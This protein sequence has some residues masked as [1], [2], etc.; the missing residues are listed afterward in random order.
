MKRLFI[1]LCVSLFSCYSLADGAFGT[2]KG[3]TKK[4]LE[5][6]GIILGNLDYEGYH[7]SD[8]APLK[9]DKFKLYK[10]KFKNNKLCSIIAYTEDKKDDAKGTNI[11]KEMLGLANSLEKEN[12]QSHLVDNTKNI[13][14]NQWMKALSNENGFLGYFYG[15]SEFNL[16]ENSPYSSIN[17]SNSINRY[18]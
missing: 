17:T 18:E 4:E 9:D 10:Y 2:Y 7:I 12:G 8:K 11:K 15:W 13:P 5:N 1:I 16:N 3:M 6:K 14:E